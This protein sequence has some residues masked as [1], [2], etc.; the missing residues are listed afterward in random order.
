MLIGIVAARSYNGAKFKIKG[1]RHIE[2]DH[3]FNGTF[4]PEIKSVHWVAE[5]T[6]RLYSS[7][8]C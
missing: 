7:S 3:V 1:R 6:P 5:G 2:M 4:W 8:C